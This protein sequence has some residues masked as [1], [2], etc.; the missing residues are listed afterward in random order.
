MADIQVPNFVGMVNAGVDRGKD[1]ALN[2]LAQ[3]AYQTPVGPDRDA[4]IG[5]AI[6]LNRDQGFDL[7]NTLQQTQDAK[8]AKLG[9]AANYVAQA[10]QASNGNPNDPKVQGAYQAVRPYLQQLHSSMGAD[11]PTPDS[12]TPDMLPGIYQIVAKT[13]GA[14]ASKLPAALQTFYGIQNQLPQEQRQQAA[15]VKAGTAARAT[16]PTF[17]PY[18]LANGDGT[19][20]QTIMNKRTG[21]LT[22]A[23]G[24]VVGQAPPAAVSQAQSNDF[25]G[26]MTPIVQQFGGQVTS[27]TRSPEHNAAVGGVPNSQHIAGTAEDVVVPPAA[28]GGFIEAINNAGLQAIDEGTHIHVQV[29]GSAQQAAATQPTSAPS[30]LQTAQPG[31]PGYVPAKKSAIQQKLDALDSFGATPEEKKAVLLGASAGAGAANGGL[32]DDSVQ[33]QGWNYLLNHQLPPLGRG[34]AGMDRQNAIINQ[35]NQIA[36]NLGVSPDEMATTA[37]RNKAYNAS[38]T[39]FTKRGDAMQAAEE[40]FKNNMDNALRLSSQMDRTGSPAVNKWLLGGEENLGDP[41]VSAFN[42]AI[43][44][45]AQDYAK[46][47]SGSTGAGGTPISTTEDAVSLFRKEL[48]D[49]QL[50]AVANVAYQD[51]HGQ[52]QANDD[53]K[54][55]ILG[56]LRSFGTHQVDM[57]G[58]STVDTNGQSTAPQ[59]LNSDDQALLGKYGVKL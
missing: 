16:N 5:Q 41:S 32:T 58:N 13:Q 52:Q 28:K 26:A 38:L 8:D 14:T 11:T 21:Q 57:Q 43:R 50:N 54:N 30:G 27:T 3:Q 2:N 46:I 47:M 17:A 42:L 19:F 56:R 22:N 7:G 1:L 44:A 36:K 9:A 39:A 25:Y 6:G 12:F 18:N 35:A 48:S 34:Q 49:K 55:R 4:I 59:P 33:S 51:I 10:W 37:G 40:G 31:Q 45:A 15:E 53:Q 23:A 20:T 24:Q 29:P